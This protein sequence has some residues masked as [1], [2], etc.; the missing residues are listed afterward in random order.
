MT[1]IIEHRTEKSGMGFA[2][3]V[4]GREGAEGNEQYKLLEQVEPEDL[5]R[6]GLIPEFVGRMPLTVALEELNREALI[7][8]LVRPK[9][10]LVKQYRKLFAL[11]DVELEF[12]DDALLAIAEKA[13][14]RKTG[15]RGLRSVLDMAMLDTMFNV[16][17]ASDKVSKIIVTREM[18]EE[19]K[20]P[21]VVRA[22]AANRITELK[23]KKS[24]GT[25]K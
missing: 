8:I 14:Q 1:K 5:I 20:E 13:Q 6:Y 11:D 25:T 12:R 17:S 7:N 18:V 10:A 9:N 24:N 22:H 3:Q 21:V 15:A 16:P 19:G 23:R 2:A 4:R